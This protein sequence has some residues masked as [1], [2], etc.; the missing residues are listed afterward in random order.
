MYTTVEYFAEDNIMNKY[1]V[2]GFRS[3]RD[4]ERFCMELTHDILIKSQEMRGLTFESEREIDYLMDSIKNKTI[5]QGLKV[6]V[7]NS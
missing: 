2:S 5:C 6:S 7:L 3:I 1:K 4:K